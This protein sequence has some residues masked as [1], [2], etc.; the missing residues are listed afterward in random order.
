M[1]NSKLCASQDCTLCMACINACP[2]KAIFMITDENGYEKLGIDSEKC[3]NCGICSKVCNRREDVPRNTPLKC[4]A[5]Q[6]TDKA[7]LMNSA[8]GGAFQMVAQYVLKN[9][10]V[11]YG[12]EGKLVNGQYTAQHIRIDSLENLD[13]ILNS[14]YVPSLIFDTYRQVKADVEKGMLALFCGTPCQIQGL[15]AF[16]GKDYDNLLTVDLIC[17]GVASTQIFNDYLDE[18][19]NRESITIVDY[20]FRDKSVSWGTNFCYSYYK[21]NDT[22]KKIRIRHCPREASSYMFN[23][24]KGNIF[25]ENCY[26]CSLSS[27]ERVGDFTFGDYWEI[28]SEHP[29]FVT[30]SKPS[31]SLK[32]GVSCILVNT[33]KA[34][35]FLRNISSEM[36]L[37][38]VAFDSIASHNSNLC[39]SSKRGRGR[40]T[41]LQTYRESGYSAVEKSYRKK[42][43]KKIIIY[44]LK[45]MLKSRLPDRI[46]ILIYKTPFL[47]KIV[48]H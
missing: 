8:S 15:K 7:K 45:N 37:H 25:R 24:L 26:Q 38:E 16:L 19:E 23:Y 9:G 22:A 31:M 2:E 18:A 17:H 28:E 36:I 34:G 6:A 43:Q 14:K 47:R 10:G 13:R 21:N 42:V 35:D 3:I 29:E 4:Y 48:F 1:N 40:E 39:R 46:R 32:K 27:G 20:Q 30:K 44:N 5:A 11:C 12:S 41:F 33:Q